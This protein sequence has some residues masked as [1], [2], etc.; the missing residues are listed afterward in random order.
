MPAEMPGE[1]F[2][3]FEQFRFPASLLFKQRRSLQTQQGLAGGLPV[4]M[5][6]SHRVQKVGCSEC[7][8]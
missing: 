6:L 8:Q 3:Q 4:A 1:Q 7:R 5:L 2:E